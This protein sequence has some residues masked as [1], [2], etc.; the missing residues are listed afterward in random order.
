MKFGHLDDVSGI[1]FTLPPDHPITEQVLDK[2]P[3]KDPNVYSGL[4]EWGNEGFP[5]KI[6]PPKTRQK[7]YLKLYGELFTCVELNATGYRVPTV[8]TVG[9]WVSAV[10]NDF[11][12]CPK[13]SQPISIT[14]PL[15]KN[16][17]ALKDFT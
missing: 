15:G 9:G 6:Y 4:A 11:I 13:V 7:D 2:K 16:E 17:K 14:S 10:P 12:F 1:D 8:K 3:V 5:G